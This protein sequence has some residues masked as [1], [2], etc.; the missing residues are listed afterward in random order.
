MSEG[1][2]T[3]IAKQALRRLATSKLEPTPENYARAYAAEAGGPL[4][5]PALPERAVAP[6]MRLVQLGVGDPAERQNLL[7]AW[8]SARW[9]EALRHAERL[10][11]SDGPAALGE[12][13]AA[14]IDQLVRGLERGGRQWTLARKKDGL[15]RVLA[16]NRGDG[17]RLAKRLRQLVS[18]WDSDAEAGVPAR[19][20]AEADAE[21]RE[22]TP[23]QFFDETEA[24]STPAP[25][26]PELER[27][28]LDLGAEVP[29]HWH[30]IAAELHETTQ[31]A[32]LAPAGDP[33]AARAQALMAQLAHEHRAAQ[34]GDPSSARAEALSRVAEQAR[35]LLAH[36]RHVMEQLGSLCQQLSGSLIDLSEDESWARGQAAVMHD[37]LAQGLS[38]FTIRSVTE[39]LAQTRDRQQQLREQRRE[40]RDALKNLVQTL[41]SELAGLSEQTDRFSHNLGRY[42]EGVEQADS[43]ESLTGLVREMLQETRTVQ[44]LVQ[45]AQGRLHSEHARAAELSERVSSLEDELRRLAEEVQTDQLTKVANRRGLLSAFEQERARQAREGGLL[46]VALLDIDNFKKLNDS[47]GHAAGDEALRGLAARA[48]AILRPGDSVARYGGEEFVLLL[49]A[50]GLDEARQ[51]LGRLQRALSAGLFMHEGK[52]VF[53]TFSAGVTLV[54]DGEALEAALERADEA[55]YEAKRT[56]KNRTCV[57]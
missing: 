7:Q 20:S 39:R 21:D 19:S 28:Q 24:L 25:A 46:A 17:A 8:K 12:Q 37:A 32:L 11:G 41:L 18:S 40:A 50:T 13:L 45:S 35:R 30:D 56:G 38:A 27:I 9:D 16:A 15:A 44:G 47:L 29:A 36:R 53:V 43:L 31:T 4:P 2:A 23:S 34:D 1:R 54:Q 48:Q 55:L 26:E 57:G 51:V 33:S 52:D 3:Q 14:T 5:E 42:A 49:P 22:G 10:M 6:L